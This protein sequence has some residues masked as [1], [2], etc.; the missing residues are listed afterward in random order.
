MVCQQLYLLVNCVSVYNLLLQMGLDSHSGSVVMNVDI[1]HRR[2]KGASKD[3]PWA[4]FRNCPA[5][6][7]G[8]ISSQVALSGCRASSIYLAMR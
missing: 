5:H 3:L 4:K 6:A 1:S 2:E 8:Q 7:C